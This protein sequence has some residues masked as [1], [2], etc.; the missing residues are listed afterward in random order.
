[1]K[2][3]RV[4][5]KLGWGFGV[6]LG[7]LLLL[8]VASFLTIEKYRVNG[9]AYKRIVQAKDLLAD[10]LPPPLYVLEA[11]QVVLEMS[12][13]TSQDAITQAHDALTTLR[14]EYDT[15]REFWKR[16]HL[17]PALATLLDKAHQP[18]ALFFDLALGDYG[19]VVR[20]GD[21]ERKLATIRK[22]RD[23]YANHRRV[24]DEVV[25]YTT[26]RGEQEEKDVQDSVQAAV[27][28]IVFNTAIAL[29]F[30]I[31]VA[32]IINRAITV[33]LSRGVWVARE[34]AKGN[35]TVHLDIAQRDEIGVLADAI[36]GM[37]VS[38]N[39]TVVDIVDQAREVSRTSV[40]LNQ[41]AGDLNQK[42]SG[43][44]RQANQ[45]A[46]TSEEM[47]V[48]MD[49]IAAASEQM[50]TSLGTVSAAAEEM[51][52][53]MT[54]ISA[55]AEEASIN[56]STVAGASKQA[57][58]SMNQVRE[59]VQQTSQNV[60]TA[61]T[62]V[63]KMNTSLLDVRSLSQTAAGEA[64]RA[65]ENAMAAYQVMKKLLV[66]AKEIDN[67]VA[68]INNIANQTN[69]LALNAAI[70]AAGAGD[71]GKG[72]AVVANEVKELARQ[73]TDATRMIAGKIADIQTNAGNAGDATCQVTEII[74]Q[75]NRSNADI[76]QAMDAQHVTLEEISRSML[77]TSGQTSAVTERVAD[78]SGGIQEV[79]RSVVEITSG[80]SEVSRS[81]LE[82]TT[83]IGEVTQRMA[84]TANGADE[85]NR[86]VAAAS[87]AI[88]EVAGSMSHVNQSADALLN[89]SKTVGR[90]AAD[91]AAIAASLD[92]KLAGFQTAEET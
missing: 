39:R 38:L 33:P 69:M 48:S 92:A 67:V 74:G 22:L 81:V 73:T 89:L 14:K 65:S 27:Y 25:A 3:W 28:W 52:T 63:E 42:A 79:A 4:G 6:V 90:Q 21:Q 83:G 31:V 50:S 23:M 51:S 15:R 30:G 26:K 86:N 34:L 2:N 7:L 61:A 24:V 36:N 57:S 66:S 19:K 87:L 13:A 64:A 82:A 44:G 5:V 37:A 35:L 17:E 77:E 12:Y 55:A 85:I 40:A 53:N 71:A 84:E 1:M 16:A 72:F 60:S 76:L 43:L 80:I 41:L 8:S 58:N 29:L 75:L 91:M 54:T 59:V 20:S 70:E 78:A 9:P 11:W 56:L 47:S 46:A 62:A 88:R 32:W 49:T 10:I 18:A 68:V 45:V